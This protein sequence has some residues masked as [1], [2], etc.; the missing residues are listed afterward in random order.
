MNLGLESSF[1]T[2]C[3]TLG[4]LFNLSEPQVPHL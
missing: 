3:V 4:R 1:T 2:Y